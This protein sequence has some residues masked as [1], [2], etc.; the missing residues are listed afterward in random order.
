MELDEFREDVI[1]TVKAKA[2]I[3]SDF[4][5]S[6]FVNWCADR[7]IEAEEI[8]EFEPCFWDKMVGR[9]RLV[10][11]GFS[12]DELDGSAKLVIA[13]YVG[14]YAFHSLTFSELERLFDRLRFFLE[15][16]LTGR[17]KNI[18]EESLPAYSVCM[19]L[20]DHRED[21]RRVKLYVVSD[22]VLSNRVKD[23]APQE[24]GDI[25]V[26]R[27][28]WDVSRFH[29]IFES[30]SG[31]DEL[32]V[33]FTDGTADG[34]PCLEASQSRENI[35][36]YLCVLPGSV[37]AGIYDRYGSR[38]LE[39]NVR[40]FLSSS[41]KVNRGIRKTIIESPE[42]FFAFN[43][44]IAATASHVEVISKQ[45]GL[46][47]L[48]CRD[49]QIVNGGQ[50]TASLLNAKLKDKADLAQI[51]VPMKLTVI[52][53]DSIESIIPEISRC[54][55][56]QNKVS[57]A[58]FFSNHRFHIRM[59]EFSRR[60]WAPAVGGAQHESHWFYER[61]RGQYLNAQSKLGSRERAQ[62][63][64]LNPRSQLVTKTDLAKFRNSWDQKPHVV[65]LGAQKNFRHFA[66][67]IASKWDTADTQY[68]EDYFRTSVA[69]AILFKYTER[70]VSKQ[71]W[72]DGGFRAQ[73]VTYSISKLANIVA[74][75]PGKSLDLRRIWTEQDVSRAIGNQLVLITR[76]AHQ[77][78]SNPS[79]GFANQTEW[80]KK[81]LCWRELESAEVD[82]FSEFSEELTD[83]QEEVSQ[84]RAARSDQKVL[85][86]IEAQSTVV[87][88]GVEYW[89][90]LLTWGKQNNLASP[91]DISFL[92]VA[93]RMFTGGKPPSDKQSIRILSIRDRYEGNGFLSGPGFY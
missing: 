90:S 10:I 53:D 1:E 6:A 84:K 27:Q 13:D 73:I 25:T 92:N 3:D 93:I 44:G 11:H 38:L 23:L 72:Y 77:V 64:L 35:R 29:R 58:D 55:N 71:E 80:C 37:L 14:D 20:Y 88:L 82:I 76:S 22:G 49:L 46:Q 30:S 21:L 70:L 36:A 75:L 4:E 24:I 51:F 40:A 61:A 5:V 85:N 50:T 66:E 83:L 91:E 60:I 19:T 62:F 17:L 81:E 48:K 12:Y 15:E 43:N 45:S 68:N 63:S 87:M 41:G 67:G 57:D 42:M 33:D 32:V 2:R 26:E 34:I 89:T 54:A 65:S 59:E 39:G 8:D 79:R 78:I 52:D 18:V 31:R 7:L 86:G 74:K 9:H 69:L 47:L 16:S 56:S 28:V